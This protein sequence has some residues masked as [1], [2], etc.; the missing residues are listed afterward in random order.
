MT[1]P[2]LSGGYRTISRFTNIGSG[3]PWSTTMDFLEQTQQ[4]DGAADLAASL[5]T[6]WI[7]FFQT[8]I[9]A[10][11]ADIGSRFHQDV[12]LSE[13][14]VYPLGTGAASTIRTA[15]PGTG[16]SGTGTPLPPDVSVVL[17]K[18]TAFRGRSG[19]GR[20][21][22]AGLEDGAPD[23]DGFIASV[24]VTAL[25]AG[26]NNEFLSLSAIGYAWDLVIITPQ[27]P[28]PPPTPWV[29]VARQVT[30]ISVDRNFDTQR[31]RGL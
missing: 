9:G 18:R 12:E 7:D 10:G 31:R 2:T 22:L 1:L 19:R 29:P 27:T 16:G 23:G 4:N 14:E 24:L 3:R 6:A 5:E 13:I 30:S 21:Y 28:P 25:Q 15:T 26:A 11:P 8:L 20:N 17:S